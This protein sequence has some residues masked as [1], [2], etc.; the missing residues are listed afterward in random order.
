[1]CSVL[2]NK[3]Q[4]LTVE[5]KNL[6]PICEYCEL[7]KRPKGNLFARMLDEKM[8][9]DICPLLLMSQQDTSQHVR[10]MAQLRL[11]NKSWK[12]VV[13]NTLDWFD[14]TVDRPGFTIESLEWDPPPGPYPGSHR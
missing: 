7:E 10:L 4:L 2:R 9:D 6:K 14:H 11:L 1:V 5:A 3:N 13:N 12:K 8:K